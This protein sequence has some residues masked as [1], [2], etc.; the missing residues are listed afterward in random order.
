MALMSWPGTRTPS[1]T[2]V[3]VMTSYDDNDLREAG[4]GLGV[5]EL[6]ARRATQARDA[7]EKVNVDYGEL[8]A[9]IDPA[10]AQRP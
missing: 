8:P 2:A 3:T 7:G 5:K 9:I 1:A 10:Q 6:V 4:Y